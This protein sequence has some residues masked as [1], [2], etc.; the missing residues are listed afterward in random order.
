MCEKTKGYRYKCPNCRCTF[1]VCMKCFRGQ[2][3]CSSNCSTEARTRS[4]KKSNKRYSSTPHGR[5]NRRLAQNRLRIKK[6]VIE[7]TSPLPP[8]PVN[9]I[10][11]DLLISPIIHF[12]ECIVCKVPLV[13]LLTSVWRKRKKRGVGGNK[14]R[15]KSSN[16]ENVL[17]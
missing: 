3:Y 10:S 6:N 8:D 15:A 1:F 9:E 11:V 17:C 13:H 5:K 7:H 2:I 12:M 4:Q 16:T 14:P